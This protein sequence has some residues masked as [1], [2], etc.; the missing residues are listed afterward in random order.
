MLYTVNIIILYYNNYTVLI[1][2]IE[3]LLTAG[4]RDSVERLCA[5]VETRIQVHVCMTLDC[6]TN[7]IKNT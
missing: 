1:Q 3:G 6:E 4:E 5:N 2:Y 7:S